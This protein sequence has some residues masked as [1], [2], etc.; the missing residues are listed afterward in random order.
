MAVNNLEIQL[1]KVVQSWL[2]R[3]AA[4]WCC[5]AVVR[6]VRSGRASC[7][8]GFLS[9]FPHSIH[10]FSRSIIHRCS[11]LYRLFLYPA[12]LER[13]RTFFFHDFC[14]LI[15]R[16]C[17]RIS[18][19]P[20]GH[21]PIWTSL[22]CW[23]LGFQSLATY[24]CGIWTPFDTF[25]Y[26]R[27]LFLAGSVYIR[28]YIC[29]HTIYNSFKRFQGCLWLWLFRQIRQRC[30]ACHNGVSSTKKPT[31]CSRFHCLDLEGSCSCGFDLFRFLLHSDGRDHFHNVCFGPVLCCRSGPHYGTVCV[32]TGHFCWGLHLRLVPSIQCAIPTRCDSPQGQF[33]CFI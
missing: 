15:S 1:I 9:K 31:L 10:I 22:L 32:G 19:L 17:S 2:L 6:R 3:L 26:P 14:L 28:V 11:W 21:R 20:D 16:L 25:L 5:L 33:C 23:V 18:T 27:Y 30:G 8:I 12:C 24:F 29:R 13:R 7:I 4:G